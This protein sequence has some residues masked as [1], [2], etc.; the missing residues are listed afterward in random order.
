MR[1]RR[2]GQPSVTRTRCLLAPIYQAAGHQ[3]WVWPRGLSMVCRN[4]VWWWCEEEM[5]QH[6]P[7]TQRF[8]LE[9]FL[10]DLYHYWLIMKVTFVKSVLLFRS[11]VHLR[12]TGECGEAKELGQSCL[13]TL[14]WTLN[15]NIQSEGWKQLEIIIQY[16]VQQGSGPSATE[17][18]IHIL[19]IW[20]SDFFKFCLNVEWN[21]KFLIHDW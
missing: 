10:R 18:K 21:I 8:V 2:C 3:R 6:H 16:P 14:P 9:T 11:L 4:L 20:R 15:R 13:L 7:D 19:L 1:R 12:M 5:V 17:Q